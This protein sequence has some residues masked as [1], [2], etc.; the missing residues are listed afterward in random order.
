MQPK[1]KNTQKLYCELHAINAHFYFVHFHRRKPG[2][3]VVE[4]ESSINRTII[5]SLLFHQNLIW[6]ENLF[7]TENRLQKD[8]SVLHQ[9]ELVLKTRTSNQKLAKKSLFLCSEPLRQIKQSASAQTVYTQANLQKGYL[10]IE[11]MDY[12]TMIKTYSHLNPN[13][14]NMNV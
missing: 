12:Q 2:N 10:S 13:K 1:K 8:M 6:L 11:F 5:Q 14:T 7:F 4:M 3:S 9:D